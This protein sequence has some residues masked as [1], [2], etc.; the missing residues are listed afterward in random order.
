M[1]VLAV[2]QAAPSSFCFLFYAQA[3]VL[4]LPAGTNIHLDKEHQSYYYVSV[5]LQF[6]NASYMLSFRKAR[7][8]YEVGWGLWVF[9]LGSF[10]GRVG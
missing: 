2:L 10:V 5:T 8:F 6:L 3:E 9:G 7:L 4:V 1:Q